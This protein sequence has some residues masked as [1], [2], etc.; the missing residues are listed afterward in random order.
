MQTLMPASMAVFAPSLNSYRRFQPD[1]FAPVNRRW[2][3]NNRS[4]GLRVPMGPGVARRVEHRVAGADANPYM[5]LAGVL[6][7]LHYGL[8]NRID[9]GAAAQ[10]NVSREPD[11]ALPFKLED[12]L[13]KLASESVLGDYLGAETIAFY[14]ETKRLEHK[15]FEK[16][17]SPLEYAW[18][19]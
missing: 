8:V 4:V 5:T 13:E 2:G 10:G 3:I 15:R 12:A 14:G 19:L 17:I 7:G 6:A 1:M 9:P 16:I 11:L 18:Y